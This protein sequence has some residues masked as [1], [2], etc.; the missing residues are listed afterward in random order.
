MENLIDKRQVTAAV[1]KITWERIWLHLDVQITFAE[2]ADRESEP[3][4]YLVNGL[5]K[6]AEYMLQ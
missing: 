2:G 1:T 5:Y 3:A 6:E 4:F